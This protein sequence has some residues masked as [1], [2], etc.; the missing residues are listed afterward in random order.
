MMYT[1][2]QFKKKSTV[3]FGIQTSHKYTKL[4]MKINKRKIHTHPYLISV[5]P[6]GQCPLNNIE[7][8]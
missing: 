8:L 3:V 7:I 2:A 1:S 5:F 6:S 4:A